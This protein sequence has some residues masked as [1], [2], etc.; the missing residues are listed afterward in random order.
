MN[1]LFLLTV[2]TVLAIFSYHQISF[3]VCGGATPN[4][5]CN[6]SPP[7]PDT[8]GI[9]QD[10]NI[11]SL[12]IDVTQGAE[13][14][15]AVGN[16]INSGS[17]GDDIN[18]TDAVLSCEN[19][20]VDPMAGPDTVN[21]NDGMM[22]CGNRCVTTGGGP[23]TVNVDGTVLN[24][25]GRGINTSFNEDIVNVRNAVVNSVNSSIRTGGDN[26]VINV[27]ESV[28]NTSGPNAT[29][30]TDAGDDRVEL[31]TGAVVNG[32]IDCG[33]EFDTIIFE[34]DVPENE[35]TFFSSQ[36][37]LA[38]V[39]DGSITINGLSYEWQDCE[40]LVN[41]LVGVPIETKPIPTLSQWGLIAMAAI[42]GVV[43]LLVS[44]KRNAS[45]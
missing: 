39:P 17:D 19:H 33:S 29:I 31:G 16:C 11:E 43:G 27:F 4:F 42:L 9:Q 18:I 3:A 8:I 38:T 13:I 35:L 24:C 14:S 34:M 25:D 10:S 26:D 45:V 1:R 41:E 5:F 20:C 44:R 37:A 2:I 6:D 23:D 36:I 22:T 30:Q 28:L 15:V 12:L 7:N 21:I 32:L 40:L